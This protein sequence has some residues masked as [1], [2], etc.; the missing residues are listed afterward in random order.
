MLSISLIPYFLPSLSSDLCLYGLLTSLIQSHDHYDLPSTYCITGWGSVHTSSKIIHRERNSKE[1]S[2]RNREQFPQTPLYPANG[3]LICSCHGANTR[4]LSFRVSLSWLPSRSTGCD[5]SQQPF[6][7]TRKCRVLL[8]PPLAC[9]IYRLLS[10]S[11]ML[12]LALQLWRLRGNI[13]I[14]AAP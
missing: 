8:T 4:G 10:T 9:S 12:Q 5:Q 3:E 2:P 14:R 13:N 11:G 1:V 6:Y 7:L